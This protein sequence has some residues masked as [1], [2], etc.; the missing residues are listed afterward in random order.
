MESGVASRPVPNIEEYRRSLQRFVYTSG[1]VMQPV[2]A[3]AVELGR[4]RSYTR[5]RGRPVLRAAQVAV[6][7]SLASPIL[8]GR[9]DVIAQKISA[10]GLRLQPGRDIEISSF[11]DQDAIADAAE[12]YYQK[13]KRHGL[14]RTSP[15]PKCGATA[16]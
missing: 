4:K 8:V 2:F 16:P 15:Q 7:E 9:P 13:R 1:T 14:S 11:D 6:D 5:R 3:A 10:L 12:A